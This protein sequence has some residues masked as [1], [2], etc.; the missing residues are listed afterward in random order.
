[1]AGLRITIHNAAGVA[2]HQVEVPADVPAGKLLK[3]LPGRLDFPIVHSSGQ[4]I[5]Y[6]LFFNDR[7]IP[8]DVTLGAAGIEDGSHLMLVPETQAGA[9]SRAVSESAQDERRLLAE[10][11]ATAVETR[12]MVKL[13][14]T[15]K[16]SDSNVEHA[17][18]HYS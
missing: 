11:I 7:E 9:P 13:R 14:E 16:P 4:P 5:A 3:V 17:N 1:M 2:T 6:G 10:E 18:P 12:L 15:L 8:P